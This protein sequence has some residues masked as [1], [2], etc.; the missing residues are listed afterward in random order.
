M[1]DFERLVRVL[2]QELSEQEKLLTLLTQERAAIATLQSDRINEINSQKEVLIKGARELEKERCAIIGGISLATD[3][4]QNAKAKLADIIA[5]CGSTKVQAKLTEVGGELKTLAG[6]VQELNSQNAELVRLSLGI[7][8]S[9]IA[10]IES[11]SNESDLP[12][13]GKS[14]ALKENLPTGRQRTAA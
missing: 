14:G 13:Y 4:P 7:V 3:Q 1:D 5:C 10:I 6:T 2:E 12:S 9:T 11:S 8:T